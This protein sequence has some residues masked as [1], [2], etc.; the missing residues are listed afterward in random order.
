MAFVV[1]DVIDNRFF[2]SFW[3]GEFSVPRV[4]R[5]CRI[6]F[7]VH[8]AYDLKLVPSLVPQKNTHNTVITVKKIGQNESEGSSGQEFF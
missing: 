7:C 3:N 6:G 5:K 4:E 1:Q 2:I 8:A